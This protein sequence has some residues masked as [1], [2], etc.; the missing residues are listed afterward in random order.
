LNSFSVSVG[1]SVTT[2]AK[3]G[4]VGSTGGSTGPHLHFEE[5]LNGSA[6]RV[7]VDGKSVA[8]YG[9]TSV[10]SQNCGGGGAVGTVRTSG[11]NLTVRSGPGTSYSSAGSLANGA[12]VNISCQTNGETVTG[13]FG[14]SKIWDKVGSGKY[15]SDAYVYTGSDGMVAPAC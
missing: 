15:V 14:T 7:V 4:A 8:Y 2:G 1:T 3:I 5:R 11:P 12:T 9:N 6:Q 10:T 13:T